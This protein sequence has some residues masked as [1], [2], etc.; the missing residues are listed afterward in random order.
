LSG[1]SNGSK[2]QRTATLRNIVEMTRKKNLY[3]Q[4]QT[5]PANG[6]TNNNEVTTLHE[7]NTVISPNGEVTPTKQGIMDKFSTK[8][9][10]KSTAVQ[11]D[12]G[13]KFKLVEDIRLVTIPI[14]TCLF[15]L[16]S[17]II[18]GAILFASWEV[19]NK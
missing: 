16:L 18:F 13:V 8:M 3:V 17:Y 4:G 6:S 5:D 15:V 11:K 7:D 14:T 1:F 9:S 2:K 10:K 12:E 19:Q